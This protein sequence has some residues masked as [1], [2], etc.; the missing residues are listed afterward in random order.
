MAARA[1]EWPIRSISSRN[2]AGVRGELVARVPQI[3]EMNTRQARGPKRRVPDAVAE[4]VI[5]QGLAFGAGEQQLILARLGEPAQVQLQRRGD[6]LGNNVGAAASRRFGRADYLFAAA[7][8]GHLPG[9]P[10]G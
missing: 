4:V 5:P 6:E 3:V 1:V 7:Q 2:E 9:H 10:Y 8:C